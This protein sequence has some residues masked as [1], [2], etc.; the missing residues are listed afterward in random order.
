MVENGGLK[1]YAGVDAKL[2]ARMS[3]DPKVI[4]NPAAT[5]PKHEEIMSGVAWTPE[6]WKSFHAIGFNSDIP[7]LIKK[8]DKAGAKGLT[9]YQERKYLLKIRKLRVETILKLITELAAAAQKDPKF[10]KIEFVER[11]IQNMVNHLPKKDKQ[12]LEKALKSKLVWV[13]I[14]DLL[15]IVPRFLKS[16]WAKLTYKPL[17]VKT[18]KNIIE[19]STEEVEKAKKTIEEGKK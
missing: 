4:Q 12:L 5:P 8:A 13:M 7:D 18:I 19:A 9:P 14:Q 17:E 16:I 15:T 2:E 11:E 1:G 10:G 3:K 6:Q